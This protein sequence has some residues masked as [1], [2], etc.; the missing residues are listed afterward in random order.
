MKLTRTLR[1]VIAETSVAAVLFAQLAVAAYACPNIEGPA[2]V[3]A[4]ASAQAMPD[5][6][7]GNSASNS[8]L[9]LQ[10]CQAGEQS[11]ETQPH[12]AVPAFAAI[13]IVVLCEPVVPRAG[14]GITHISAWF[15]HAALPPPLSRSGVLRI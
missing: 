7:M 2:A 3:I 14:F 1:R 8:N 4:A 10:H 5:C 11:V 6:D 9:C 13:S 15:R 12:V